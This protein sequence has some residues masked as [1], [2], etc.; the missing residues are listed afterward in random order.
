[1]LYQD[2]SRYTVILCHVLIII[3]KSVT[4]MLQWILLPMQ[5]GHG[6]DLAKHVWRVQGGEHG[7]GGDG[8]AEQHGGGGD[9]GAE[10]H[11]GGGVSGLRTNSHLTNPGVCWLEDDFV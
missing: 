7:G 11:G 2:V 9:G 10:Q 3:S 8:G 6:V 4:K 1:M 5:G